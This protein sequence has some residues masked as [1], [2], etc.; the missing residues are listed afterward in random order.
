MDV[1]EEQYE[2]LTKYGDQLPSAASLMTNGV[3]FIIAHQAFGDPFVLIVLA[4][5]GF[6]LAMPKMMMMRTADDRRLGD[7]GPET[8]DK[9]RIDDR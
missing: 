3:V 2:N 9:R 6:V 5:L 8:D 4:L 1:L 7:R